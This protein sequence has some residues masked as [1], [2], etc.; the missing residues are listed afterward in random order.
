MIPSTRINYPEIYD[1]QVAG[2]SQTVKKTIFN[3]TVENFL[4][5]VSDTSKG[6]FNKK[7]EGRSSGCFD[8]IFVTPMH[9]SGFYN[10]NS[11][12]IN[13]N[14]GGN[15]NNN[16]AR[17]LCILGTLVFG[18][19]MAVLGFFYGNLSNTSEDVEAKDQF[20]KY[21]HEVKK[22]FPHDH[23]HLGKIN[24]IYTRY[25]SLLQKKYNREWQNCALAV[26]VAVGGAILALGAVFS[27]TGAC[28]IGGVLAVGALSIAG[29]KACYGCSRRNK[30][31]AE[32]AEIRSEYK[33]LKAYNHHKSHEVTDKIIY[34]NNIDPARP[35][36]A[37]ATPAELNTL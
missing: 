1:L 35:H 24:D 21:L 15:G 37:Q 14:Y 31:A 17:D 2:S 36:Y 10:S 5:K 4:G 34:I 27:S 8:T 33:S 29:F 19:A 26:S 18:A 25:S 3:T 9:G 20:G 28:V 32:A 6:I 23:A 7:A 13:N 30:D 22:K 11:T 12:Y 16:N